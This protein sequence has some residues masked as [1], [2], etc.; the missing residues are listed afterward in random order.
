V[1]SFIYISPRAI[2]V[3]LLWGGGRGSAQGKS[4][5]YLAV[6]GWKNPTQTFTLL[7]PDLN[8]TID[9]YAKPAGYEV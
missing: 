7:L 9:F 4:D 1:S 3:H 8:T 5:K 2:S 6:I